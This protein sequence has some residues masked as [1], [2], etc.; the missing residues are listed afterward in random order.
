M[1]PL[2]VSRSRVVLMI[3]IHLTLSVTI[4][5]IMEAF[6]LLTY[7]LRNIPR[8]HDTYFEGR[9]KQI[10]NKWAGLNMLV[11]FK[12][13]RKSHKHFSI[14]NFFRNS[15]LP[16]LKFK[17]VRNTDL[18]EDSVKWRNKHLETCKTCIS[19]C[20]KSV[21]DECFFPNKNT[22][23]EQDRMDRIE[24]V[25]QWRGNGKQRRIQYNYYTDIYYFCSNAEWTL[26]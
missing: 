3:S 22:M 10:V 19:I 1:R 24:A 11:Y 23:P 6:N 12:S 14:L 8:T 7:F 9:N 4:K 13:I 15:S 17:C 20:R 18:G 26:T 5:I 21:I 2:Q 25:S 16:D